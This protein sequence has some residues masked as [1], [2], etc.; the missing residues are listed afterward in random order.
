M[1][2]GR[3]GGYCPM[4]GEGITPCPQEGWQGHIFYEK[5]KKRL[6]IRCLSPVHMADP[7]GVS[8][9]ASRSLLG[10]WSQQP[11]KEFVLLSHSSR[12]GQGLL[13]AYSCMDKHISGQ[14]LLVINCLVLLPQT[15]LTTVLLLFITLYLDIKERFMPCLNWLLWC[16]WLLQVT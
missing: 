13:V 15:R 5:W 12:R 2:V 8:W 6:P 11:W 14:G 3:R 1:P 16:E 7:Q 4:M 9:C 10:Q